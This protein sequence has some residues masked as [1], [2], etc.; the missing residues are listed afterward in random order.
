MYIFRYV[1]SFL[2]QHVVVKSIPSWA[3]NGKHP[4]NTD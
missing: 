3:L 1:Y 4:Q 2:S